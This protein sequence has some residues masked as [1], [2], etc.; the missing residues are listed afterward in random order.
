M[1]SGYLHELQVPLHKLL[2]NY[3]GK[4]SSFAVESYGRHHI[5]Q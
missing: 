2:L 4:K 3:K 1:K 5:I